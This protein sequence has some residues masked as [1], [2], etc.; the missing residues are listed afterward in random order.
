MFPNSLDIYPLSCPYHTHKY[1][2]SIISNENFLHNKNNIL[3]KFH[4]YGFLKTEKSYQ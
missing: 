1:I 3:I 2:T 4:E